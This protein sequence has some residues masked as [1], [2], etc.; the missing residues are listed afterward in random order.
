M[1]K[2]LM[3][4]SWGTV[5][6][7]ADYAEQAITAVQAADRGI[8]VQPSAD[9]LDPRTVLQATLVEPYD[10]LWL[11]YHRGLHSRWT[12]EVTAE[13]VRR[14][15]CK[16][17]ITFHDTRGEA[18]PDD[19]QLALH[20]LADAFVVHEPCLGLPKAQ[21]IRQG[22][23]A[24]VT[25]RLL[26]RSRDVLAYP[27][28][29]VLGT[30]GFNFPWKN[31]DRIAEVTAACGWALLILSCNA[32]YED[33]QRWRTRNPHLICVRQF[34]P[35]TETVAWLSGCDATIFA[36]ECANTGTSGAIRQGIAARKPVVAWRDCRQFRDLRDLWEYEPH[37]SPPHVRWCTT[38]D[39]LPYIL[40]V[41][42]L[43]ACDPGIVQLAAT[44]SWTTQGR[45]YAAIL[46][47]L[48][49]GRG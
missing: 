2:V 16:C 12:P 6:G 15:G 13:V 46:T 34:L 44:D 5:C 30:V 9:A 21:V 39:R 43:G 8:I 29:P 10:V 4:T 31:Y 40:A 49:E 23:P 42:P 18:Q 19:L 32:T 25:A 1:V 20:D 14:L 47:G 28:Q 24:G 41:L 36:Y 22:I 17:L 33:E 48:A 35:T 26:D 45:K 3:A 38:F 27:H 11:N 7:I 37:L